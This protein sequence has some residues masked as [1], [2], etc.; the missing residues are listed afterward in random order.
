MEP[1]F[2]AAAFPFQAQGR[3]PAV[4]GGAEVISKALGAADADAQRLFV[5][6]L[7]GRRLHNPFRD[8]HGC[9]TVEHFGDAVQLIPALYRKIFCQRHPHEPGGG[10]VVSRQSETAP[11]PASEAG[12][13]ASEDLL[14]RGVEV[15]YGEIIPQICPVPRIVR[16]VGHDAQAVPMDADPRF[17]GL[18]NYGPAR[19]VGENI[20]DF[21]DVAKDFF[22]G[23]VEEGDAPDHFLHAGTLAE[24]IIDEKTGMDVE[25]PAVSLR[26]IDGIA[27]E[28]EKSAH[29]PLFIDAV[30]HNG[31]VKSR[32]RHSCAGVFCDH[33]MTA[34]LAD[35]RFHPVSAGDMRDTVLLKVSKLV[36]GSSK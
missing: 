7:I 21:H 13:F 11:G 20:V 3:Y 32:N 34:L 26:V 8:I 36:V 24:E 18:D 4:A 25:I 1:Y 31:S 29:K 27:G 2:S 17:G 30:H 12:E 6:V 5:V 35:F 15:G 16:A 33:G 10:R 9:E 23:Q 22:S 14:W 28:I 19:G